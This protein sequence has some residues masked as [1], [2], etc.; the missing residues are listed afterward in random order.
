VNNIRSC[1][2]NNELT[3]GGGGENFKLLATVYKVYC[4]D[5]ITVLHFQFQV[6]VK[7]LR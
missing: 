5:N 6:E 3:Y 2:K 4:T 7:V 1:E